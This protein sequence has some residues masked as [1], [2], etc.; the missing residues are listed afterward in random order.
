VSEQLIG[1]IVGALIGFG[2]TALVTLF[3]WRIEKEKRR[4]E[5]LWHYRQQHV[6]RLRL[7]WEEVR[8]QALESL[9]FSEKIA[10]G[11]D[12][13]AAAEDTKTYE[14]IEEGLE[15]WVPKIQPRF[16]RD[17]V[18]SRFSEL[19]T[20]LLFIASLHDPSLRDSI[21]KATS[22]VIDGLVSVLGNVQSLLDKLDHGIEIT[23]SDAKKAVEQFNVARAIIVA[24]M[25]E[26]EMS[27]EQHTTNV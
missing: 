12:A 16:D 27:I 19:M 6:Q 10:T 14:E 13:L 15:E 26:V 7:A 9:R 2:G 22:A 8:R 11:L 24:A 23:P 20:N 5:R 18:E 17:K 1:V 21:N 3:Q 4:E 25:R